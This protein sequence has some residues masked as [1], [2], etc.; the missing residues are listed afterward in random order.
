MGNRV[1]IPRKQKPL[2]QI[3]RP[4]NKHCNFVPGVLARGTAFL[5]LHHTNAGRDAAVRS[6][7]S[8][9][10]PAFFPASCPNGSFGGAVH[11]P[12]L[13]VPDAQRTAVH[14]NSRLVSV[15]DFV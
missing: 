2:Q 9:C 15:Q 5:A 14:R 11:K 12:A 6:A 3:L 10:L 1:R 8:A 13:H 7:P 4:K